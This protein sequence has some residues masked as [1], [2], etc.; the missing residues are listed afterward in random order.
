MQ[1][2]MQ[3]Q[4]ISRGRC[5]GRTSTSL[6]AQHSKAPYYESNA[7]PN[8][9]KAGKI[10]GPLPWEDADEP[11]SPSSVRSPALSPLQLQQNSSPARQNGGGDWEAGPPAPDAG[12]HL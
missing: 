4:A 8:V 1:R 6:A 12:L 5:R 7:Q 3:M 11:D 9:Q 2:N 10:T